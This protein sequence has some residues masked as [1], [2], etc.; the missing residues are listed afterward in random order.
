ML[1]RV[2]CEECGWFDTQHNVT[3]SA[4]A[5]IY[6]WMLHLGGDSFT[7]LRRDNILEIFMASQFLQVK[8]IIYS[9]D[10]S[11]TFNSFMLSL[12]FVGR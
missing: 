5:S 10:V 6:D 1:L 12:F 7:L 8:G 4:F 11:L 2:Y 3:K 9:L